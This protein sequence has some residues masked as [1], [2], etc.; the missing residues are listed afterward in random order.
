V[1]MVC[2]WLALGAALG[3]EMHTYTW[4]M[5]SMVYASLTFR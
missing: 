5:N 1:V 3:V 2:G 4:R